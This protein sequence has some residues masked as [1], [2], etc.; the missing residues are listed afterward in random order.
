MRR[1]VALIWCCITAGAFA[2]TDVWLD[3]DTSIGLPQG[4]VDDGLALIQAFHSPELNIRGISVV[5]GNTDLEK[6]VPIARAITA[7]FGPENMSVHPGAGSAEEFG[8]ENDAVKAMAAALRE[9]PMTILALGPVTNVG[10]L[11]KLHPED[12]EKVER[13]VMVAARRPGQQFRT[14]TGK[15]P[16]R[17][18]NFE[19][20]PSAM[21]ALLDSK[22]ELVFAPWE[23]SSKV[24]VRAED[25]EKLKTKSD[26]GKFLTEACQSW[27]AMWKSRFGVDGFNPFDTLG[28]GWVTHPDLIQT[29]R[30][31]VWIE[32][33]P[34]DRVTEGSAPQNKP[35]LLV[36]KARRDRRQALYCHT[37]EP[38]F[39]PLLLERLAARP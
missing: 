11:I 8:Q 17:D 22:I 7:E 16:H 3:V 10:S 1:L 33:G 2:Q 21:Q 9:K 14:G 12:H 29:I 5:F 28:V 25:L 6:A 34:D 32:E 38:A 24:W 23:V 36:D 18:F 39:T 15:Q 27:L 4:E 19:L 37:P 30:V 26:S 31:G 35:Y 13:I 20:D